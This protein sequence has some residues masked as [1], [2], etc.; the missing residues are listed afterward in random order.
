[1]EAP[2]GVPQRAMSNISRPSPH[3][4]TP[5][6]LGFNFNRGSNYVPC[7]VTLDGGR[8]V[9]ARYV[10]VV[11]SNDPYVIGIVLGDDNHY[12]SALLLRHSRDVHST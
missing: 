11:M 5:P 3:T 8:R 2:P 9:P 12:G 6:L 4:E 10:R 1:M 7:L